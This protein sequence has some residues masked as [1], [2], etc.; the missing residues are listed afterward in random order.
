MSSAF[1]PISISPTPSSPTN[2]SSVA[3]PTTTTSNPVETTPL[4]SQEEREKW[5]E[6][7][8]TIDKEWKKQSAIERK[9]A[10]ETRAR[11]AA[12]RA[13]TGETWEK[14]EAGKPMPG[15]PNYSTFEV[16]SSK[17]SGYPGSPSP[18]DVR[19]VVAGEPSTN[20]RPA[21]GLFPSF[22][23]FRFSKKSILIIS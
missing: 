19:S 21:V 8:A 18:A 10:E 22:F 3:E 23:F 13:S 7:L 1:T 4:V 14:L 12:E 2:E 15:P 5:E 16:G 11:I 20:T 17:S 6:E 9:K